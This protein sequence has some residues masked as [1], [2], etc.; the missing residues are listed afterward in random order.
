MENKKQIIFWLDETKHQ[1]FKT[2]AYS[3]GSDITKEL[4]KFVDAFIGKLPV[5]G[6]RKTEISSEKP[7]EA[8]SE[9]NSEEL[10]E[11]YIPG[12]LLSPKQEMINKLK[13]DIGKIVPPKGEVGEAEPEYDTSERQ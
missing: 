11:N 13:S 1:R 5:A 8:I 6:E 7:P 10:D 3:M 4:T 9:N 2:K 12:S